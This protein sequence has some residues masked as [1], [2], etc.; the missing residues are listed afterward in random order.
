MSDWI[1]EDQIKELMKAFSQFDT[2][3]DGQ[4]GVHQ[5]RRVL[6]TLGQNPTDAELQVRS[7]LTGGCCSE[8]ILEVKVQYEIR[9]KNSIFKPLRPVFLNIW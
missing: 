3:H 9:L 8:I 4:I 1:G 6:H 7:L 2:D 5:L